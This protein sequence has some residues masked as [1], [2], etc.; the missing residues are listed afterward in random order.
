M[1][2]IKKG[3]EKSFERGSH[4]KEFLAVDLGASNGR[5]ILGRFDGERLFLN[6]LN[7]FENNYV[8]VG[9]SYYWDVLHLYACIC[10]GLQIYAKNGAGEL[11]GIG[12]DTWGVDFGL[13]DKAGRLVSNPRSYRDPRGGRG[14]KA[15]NKK[16]GERKA[17]DLT[18]IADME[19]NTIY[20][21]CDMVLTDDPG[22]KIADKLLLMPDLLGYM[23]CGEKTTEYTN[24][25]TMQ[26]LD[27]RT[28]K[29]SKDLMGMVGVP[30]SLFTEIQM[31]GEVKGAL[32]PSIVSES[33]LK[34][35][36]NVI[37]VGSHDTAS[38]VASVPA[39]TD[40]YAFISSGTW[41]LMGIVSDHA[42]V[43]DEMYQNKFSNEGT[44]TGSYR[45][46]KNIMGL[47]I[48]QNCKRQWDR[49]EKVSWDDIVQMAMAAKPF[50]SFIDVN[51]L[52]FFGGENMPQKI[53]QYCKSTG[54]RVPETKGEIARTVYE[55]LA[56]SYRETFAGLE[57]M[58]GRKI[59]AL[60]IVGGG[61]KNRL[62]NQFTASAVGREV[63][64]GPG[65]ATAIGNLMMQVKSSGEIKDMAQMRQAIRNSFDVE[66]YEPKDASAWTEQFERYLSVKKTD[67]LL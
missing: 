39:T 4:M 17:F 2:I 63:I 44:V 31:S 54:Q 11:V 8:R 14:K 30:E 60:H 53:Q 3:N 43:N 51:S 50:G 45:P 46:L 20:Q 62:L 26:M 49:E 22:L 7:R 61:S 16:Y 52:D 35:A 42:I 27:S 25:T 56:M 65:E 6:E 38:A 10:E 34:A 36:P 37:C 66:S 21:L 5:T 47:W 19:F 23:L 9:D 32:Y 64:A 28:G 57:K 40:N 59:D 29:W 33:G 67:N 41:S 55:S 1:P 12:I 48:I 15:F 58:K 18:G 13:I 24:A